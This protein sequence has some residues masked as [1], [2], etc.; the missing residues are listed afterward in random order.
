M[1]GLLSVSAPELTAEEAVWLEGG[2]FLHLN[3]IVVAF[4]KNLIAVLDGTT[5]PEDGLATDESVI[6][7]W[8]DYLADGDQEISWYPPIL[9]QANAYFQRVAIVNNLPYRPGMTQAA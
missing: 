9:A 4:G 1:D 6:L 2:E 7:R 5:D 8:I 3:P